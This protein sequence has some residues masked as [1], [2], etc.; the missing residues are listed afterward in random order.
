MGVAA[1]IGLPTVVMRA[2]DVGDGRVRG[3][4]V[5]TH[6]NGND[7]ARDGIVDAFRDAKQLGANWVAIHPYA[8]IRDDGRVEPWQG[9]RNAEPIARPVREAHALGLKI[10][11]V[12]HLAQWGSHFRWRGDISFEQEAAWTRF[13]A[14]YAAWIGQVVKVA[15][16]ADAIALG[17]ELDRT[18]GH[19]PQWRNL[20][21]TA[22]AGTRAALTYAANWTDY[23]RVP[24]WDALDAIGVQAY[25]PLVDAGVARP[26]RSD[27]ERGWR[28]RMQ[29]LRAFADKHHKHVV[30]TELGYN[31]SHTAAL[32][33]WESA[34]D[35]PEALALQTL[36]L[37]VA[38]RAVE[39]EPRVVGAFLWKW[40]PPPRR[41]GR[42]FQLATP[43]AMRVIEDAWKR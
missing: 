7:W 14:G 12:P 24:F 11:V 42:D 16:D 21:A 32:T 30:F 36:C 5:S 22:R 29:A 23:E 33:P 26:V 1:I 43:E 2:P 40:F 8:R 15:A 28:A 9:E 27:L 25:F 10:M 38:L 3:I 39:Q 19:E 18:V 35:G 41:N 6:G 37:D 31:R 17:S 20:I 34:S 4:T 13:F